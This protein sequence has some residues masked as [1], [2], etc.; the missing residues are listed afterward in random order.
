MKLLRETI[1]ARAVHS[2]NE[3]VVSPQL[4]KMAFVPSLAIRRLL[5]RITGKGELLD[6]IQPEILSRN[7]ACI[8]R[9]YL[10]TNATFDG[11]FDIPLLALTWNNFEE[12]RTEILEGD[13]FFLDEEP[14]GFL[15]EGSQLEHGD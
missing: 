8:L 11:S 13:E 6:M 4:E 7:I 14:L 2:C 12:E 1:R 5:A 15:D 10:N 3:H 9:K